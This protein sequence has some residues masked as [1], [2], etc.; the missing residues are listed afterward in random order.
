MCVWM[1]VVVISLLTGFIDNVETAAK[2][3]FGDVIMSAED[4]RGLPYYDE[5]IAEVTK[6]VPEVKAA[7]P[8]ILSYGMLRL[9]GQQDYSNPVQIAGIRLPGHAEVSD[10]EEGLLVQKD[11]KLTWDPPTEQLLESLDKERERTLKVLRGVEARELDGAQ[12][13]LSQ[14][15][16]IGRI[17]KA[18]TFQRDAVANLR[19]SDRN[20][21]YLIS[22]QEQLD[23]AMAEG[24]GEEEVKQAREAL[25][26]A[27]ADK[28][29]PEKIKALADEY[30]ELAK[31]SE[32]L[33]MLERDVGL[34]ES[35]TYE[36]PENRIILG[37]G[38]KALS[39]RTDTREV[40]RFW[41]PGRKVFL[42]IFP[43]GRGGVSVTA[44]SP[45]SGNFS[46]IDDSRSGVSPIDSGFVY[47]PFE[48]LQKLNHMDSDG[49]PN[50]PA[51]C[52]QIIFKV[53]KDRPT[54]EELGAIRD[55]IMDTWL[56]FRKRYPAAALTQADVE[57]WRERQHEL[58]ST[59]EGQRVMMIIVLGIVSVVAVI[60]IFVILYVIVMQK[61][62]DIG[63]LKAV[64]ASSM[65]VARVFLMYGAALGAVGAAIGVALGYAFVRNIKNIAD[66]L[67]IEFGFTPFRYGFLFDKLPDEVQLH[68]VVYIVIAAILSG[69]FGALF[70]ALK[71]A[72]MQP[73]EALRYE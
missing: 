62:A 47:V 14:K 25:T 18:M 48:T 51:R 65:G 28:L 8:Y 4:Q 53:K 17:S 31:A 12:M 32:N 10:F 56:T 57:T 68:T 36:P 69:I 42:Y 73:V 23:D 30:L 35:Q 60:L 20:R 9:S 50:D 49:S 52:S 40:V 44:M 19:N 58:L 29:P 6:E 71:A 2:G 46:V 45:E 27:Q 59:V 72:R 5:F 37:L 61:T 3:L 1:M 24:I 67:A 39:F 21:D 22:K 16:L 54:E 13:S 66:W 64:G 41:V 38:I 26:Q 34:L 55:K 63:I 33:K 11:G 70:P 15:H 7:S 43:L